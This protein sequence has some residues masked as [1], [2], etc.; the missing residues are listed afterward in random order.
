LF[1]T[2]VVLK[3]LGGGVDA[4]TEY[5]GEIGIFDL[6]VTVGSFFVAVVS[7]TTLIT[8]VLSKYS[9]KHEEK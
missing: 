1:L 8:F 6:L 9:Y 5:V 4:V 2:I 7:V 3:F